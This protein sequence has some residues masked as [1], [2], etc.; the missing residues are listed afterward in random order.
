MTFASDDSGAKLLGI[1]QTSI[2]HNIV[3]LLFGIAGLALSRTWE[4]SLT[5]MLGG[6]ALYA[7]LWVLGLAGGA[8]WLPANNA[9][10]CLHLALGATML[11]LGVALRGRNPGRDRY[12]DT[13]AARA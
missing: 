12:E 10:D 1:C 13:G 6:D 11:G 3:H 8:D 2:L 7:A 5:F 4:G 9:D